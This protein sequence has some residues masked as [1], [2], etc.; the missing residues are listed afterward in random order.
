MDAVIK[1]VN[2]IPLAGLMLTV[3]LGYALSLL[4][5]RGISL[6]PAGATILVA[7]V[8]GE[9]GLTVFSSTRALT[10]GSVG[11][12]GRSVGALGG[13][14]FIYMVG[15]DA[16]PDFFGALRSGRGWKF[17]LVGLII[18]LASVGVIWACSRLFELDAPTSAGL[19]AGAMTS[20]PSFAASSAV[21]TDSSRLAV[22][23]A[24]AYPIGLA[25]FG[26]AL[27]VLPRLIGHDLA[28][29]TRSEHEE[30]ESI[31]GAAPRLRSPELFRTFRVEN[32]P[33]CGKPLRELQIN[34]TT[35]CVIACVR[36]AGEVIYPDA[37]TQLQ[38]RDVIQAVGR[39]D[40]LEK[41]SRA[42]GPEV[43]DPDLSTLLARARR[44]RVLHPA[45]CGK[46]LAELEILR[47][48]RCIV[49][50]IERGDEVL[51]PEAGFKV[52]RDDVLDL[53]GATDSV[54]AA[55]RALGQFESPRVDTNIA[56][57]A[58]GLLVGLLIGSL[59][60]EPFG[61]ELAAGSFGGALVAGILMGAFRRIGR[62]NFT[63]P[64]PA[65]HLIRDFGLLLFVAETGLRAGRGLVQGVAQD[66]WQMLVTASMAV[67]VPALVGL[68]VA[69]YVL[70]LRVPD[71]WGSIAGGMTSSTLPLLK[72]VADSNEPAVSFAAA[73][74]AATLLLTVAGQLLTQL[75]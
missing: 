20:A 34:R 16:G 41:F 18:P 66:L 33:V 11:A 47:A 1:F 67:L 17:A 7:L 13:L 50:R 5:L 35:G 32:Q 57:F 59:Q 54:R 53:M 26:V 19:L 62:F 58:G 12:T 3:A 68:V 61:V 74:A 25:G 49:V 42:V 44:V 14:L 4:K 52:A 38:P 70:R 2:D 63:V 10:A 56:L 37:G 36:R 39:L 51:E 46:A 73:Y 69:R 8:L 64:R 75:G 21:L 48:Q 23:F 72:S 29:G 27:Q 22:S 24:L 60:L 45:A 65:R 55:A 30:P 28:K 6:G 31:T 15:Y 9:F 40:E 71:A 43:Y